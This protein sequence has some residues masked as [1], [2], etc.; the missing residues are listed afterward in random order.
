MK[1]ITPI[2]FSKGRLKQIPSMKMGEEKF[3]S[4]LINF[5]LINK[6]YKV[7]DY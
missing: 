2:I 5:L 1:A 6:V 7:L 4:N 3:N